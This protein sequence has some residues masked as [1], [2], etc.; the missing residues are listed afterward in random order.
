MNTYTIDFIRGL[1]VAFCTTPDGRTWKL[2]QAYSEKS[3]TEAYVNEC[4][5]LDNKPRRP[6][7]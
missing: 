6:I 7:F 5:A 2:P 4:I 3:L 1:Y